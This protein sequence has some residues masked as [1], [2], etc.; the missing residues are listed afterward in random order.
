MHNNPIA[1]SWWER[2]EAGQQ[3]SA[4]LVHPGAEPPRC[5][6]SSRLLNSRTKRCDD[7]NQYF[8]K[9]ILRSGESLICI[10]CLRFQCDCNVEPH[11]F[12]A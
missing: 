4:R 11:I 2:S 3:G 7:K 5:Q 6:D 12:N 10:N 9:Y 1:V 8:A